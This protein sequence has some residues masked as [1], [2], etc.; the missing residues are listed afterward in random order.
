MSAPVY[1]LGIEIT[2]MVHATPTLA[3]FYVAPPLLEEE[4]QAI[5][6]NQG[7]RSILA[8]LLT[9][10]DTDDSTAVFGT[11][12]FENDTNFVMGEELAKAVMSVRGIAKARLTHNGAVHEVLV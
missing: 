9:D 2:D 6:E 11:V 12:A 10:R 1:E 3:N 5:L 7:P 4:K 8:E